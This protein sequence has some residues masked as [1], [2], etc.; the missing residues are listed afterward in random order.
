MGLCRENVRIPPVRSH[1]TLGYE[2][3]HVALFSGPLSRVN[4]RPRV[5]LIAKG[6]KFYMGLYSEMFRNLLVTKH[7]G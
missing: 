5:K 4:Y 3:L 2:M 1:E 6:H 7:Y